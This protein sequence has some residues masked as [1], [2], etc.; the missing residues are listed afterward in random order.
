[1]RIS[2]LFEPIR[3][4]LFTGSNLEALAP[5]V[6]KY[7]M[8]TIIQ[9]IIIRLEQLDKAHAGVELMSF[10]RVINSEGLYKQALEILRGLAENPKVSTNYRVS[11]VS[12][13]S[14]PAPIQPL[15]GDHIS[16]QPIIGHIGI[17]SH[18]VERRYCSKCRCLQKMKCSACGCSLQL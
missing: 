10:S 12:W 2:N 14:N 9:A 8:D 4:D 17:P 13:S 5:I 11:Q 16:R 1:M 3:E 7:S 18:S 6:A 15:I